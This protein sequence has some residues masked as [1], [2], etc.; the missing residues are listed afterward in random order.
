[1]YADPEWTN[2]IIMRNTSA[3][4]L[5]TGIIRLSQ[6][7][8][9]LEDLDDFLI[10]LDSLRMSKCFTISWWNILEKQT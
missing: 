10:F 7:P 3:S 1:M 2:L 5:R 9:H 6:E 4:Y 8:E